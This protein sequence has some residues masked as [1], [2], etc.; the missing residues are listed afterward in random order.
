M[1][2]E[3]CKLVQGILYFQKLSPQQNPTKQKNLNSGSMTGHRRPTKIFPMFK[4]GQ[5]DQQNKVVLDYSPN[6][7]TSIYESILIK[8]I[9]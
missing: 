7:K 1:E 6:F 2:Q 5:F 4:A 8:M 9:R 3:I